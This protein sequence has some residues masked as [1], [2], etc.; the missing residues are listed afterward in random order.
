MKSGQTREVVMRP[1]AAETIA[2]LAGPQVEIAARE[3]AGQIPSFVPR[4]QGVAAR[5][6]TENLRVEVQEDG[7]AAVTGLPFLWHW[8]EYGTRWNT[9]YRPIENTARALGLN[10]NGRS[11]T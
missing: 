5:Q 11:T 2:K 10:W 3:L 4:N 1:D 6:Y 7:S 9:P 8:L